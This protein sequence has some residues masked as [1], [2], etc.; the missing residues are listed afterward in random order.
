MATKKVVKKAVAKK[1]ASKKVTKKAVKKTVKK[2][3]AKKA[4]PKKLKAAKAK[5]KV[6]VCAGEQECFWTTDGQIL[7]D[8]KELEEALDTMVDEVFVHHVTKEKNDFADWVESILLDPMCA[9]EMRRA[10]KVDTARKVVKR[11]LKL[12]A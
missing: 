8:L 9:A 5:D 11:H 1:A 6:L 4:A 3:V 10:R 12:Y 2:A 7:A